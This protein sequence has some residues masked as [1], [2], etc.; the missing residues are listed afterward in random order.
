MSNNFEP[1]ALGL[2]IRNARIENHL[3]QEQLAELLDVT[4][5]HVKHIESGHRK[6][7]INVLFHIATIL[8]L[9]LDALIFP[10]AVIAS[11][12]ARDKALRLLNM[13]EDKYL[14]TVVS[15]LESLNGIR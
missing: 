10:K 4:V 7:S 6:P 13:C 8:N 9:S 12:P 2:S 5:T 15:L 1:I 11:N 14:N 3:T